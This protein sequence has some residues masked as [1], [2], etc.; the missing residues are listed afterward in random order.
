MSPSTYLSTFISQLLSIISNDSFDDI[1][2][3]FILVRHYQS[4]FVC[5]NLFVPILFVISKPSII[6]QLLPK[7]LALLRVFVLVT[8]LFDTSLLLLIDRLDLLTLISCSLPPCWFFVISQLM[9]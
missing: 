7:L 5:G 9:G 1:A 4:S 8:L 6:H 3:F 2:A